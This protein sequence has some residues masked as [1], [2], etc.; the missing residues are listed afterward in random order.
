M[1]NGMADYILDE[2]FNVNGVA[3]VEDYNLYCHYVAGLVGEG[4]TNLLYWLIL[5]INIDRK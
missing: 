1:G 2:E 5:V 3:T 4:L